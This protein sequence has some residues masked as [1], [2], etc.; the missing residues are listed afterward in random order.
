MFYNC[1]KTQLRPQWMSE[2]QYFPMS[3]KQEEMFDTDLV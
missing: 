3:L 1:I 2:S